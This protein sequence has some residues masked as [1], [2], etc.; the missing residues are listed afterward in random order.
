VTISIVIFA[1]LGLGVSSFLNVCIDRLPTGKSIIRLPSHCNSCNQKLQARDLVPLFSYLWLRGRCRYCGAR[2]PIRLPIVELATSLIFAFLTWFAFHIWGC[3][4]SLQLAIALIYACIFLV[5]FVI[6][7]EKRL[8]LNRVVYPGMALA[9]AFSFFWPWPDIGWPDIG[10]L[11]ALLGGAIGF[12]FMLLPYL[13][14]R[15]VYGPEAMGGGDVMLAG[16]IG[17]VSGFPLVIV[18]LLVGIL[19]G[20]LV[21]VS[22]LM[23]RLKGRKEAIPFGPFLA[24]AA[25]VILLWGGQILD[26][27]MSFTLT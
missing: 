15:L 12:G 11:S 16:L 9:L 10:V 18:A 3:G 2:I 5:I 13:I 26:W 27:Y 25:M 1:L 6:D 19:S 8:I 7:L 20:G 14:S 22:L 24:A 23:L 4:L 17:M 21:A